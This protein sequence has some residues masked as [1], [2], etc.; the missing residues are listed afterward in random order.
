M[1]SG[2]RCGQ[3]DNSPVSLFKKINK[4][5]QTTLEHRCLQWCPRAGLWIMPCLNRQ[6]KSI[7]FPVA[8]SFCP[9]YK[10]RLEKKSHPRT[11]RHFAAPEAQRSRTHSWQEIN[12]DVRSD[13]VELTPV[14]RQYFSTVSA[15]SQH[16]IRQQLVLHIQVVWMYKNMQVFFLPSWLFSSPPSPP[17]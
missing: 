8:T 3:R 9:L 10:S 17:I 2:I 7:W 1:H 11:R 12:T 14:I 16:N 5:S 13:E 6:I 4:H 15:T